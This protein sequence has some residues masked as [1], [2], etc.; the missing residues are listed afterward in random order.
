MLLKILKGTGPGVLFLIILTLI[1]VWISPFL[2][3]VS[4]VEIYYNERPMLLFGILRSTLEQNYTAGILFSMS[5]VLLISYILVYFNTSVF[6]IGERTYLPAFVYILLSGLI[7]VN[8]QLNPALPASL[9]LILAIMRIVESYRIQGTAFSFF[10]AGFLIATGSLFYANLIWYGAL[11]LIGILNIRAV[12]LKEILLSLTGLA[13]PFLLSI[14]VLYVTGNDIPMFLDDIRANLFSNLPAASPGRFSIIS[15][16]IVGFLI[17]ISAAYLFSVIGIK[18]IKSRKAF[19]IIIW[20][21]II[22]GVLYFVLPSA[23][24]ETAWI[25]AIPSAYFLSHFFTLYRRKTIQEILFTLMC[26]IVGLIQVLS[27]AGKA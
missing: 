15:L 14:G 3:P 24:I 17:L 23:S 13:T 16:A 11:L 7:P 22:S 27:I 5:L 26:F 18:K 6:F 4:P 2:H 25:I 12:N 19:S 1:L 21:L 8:Q 10:D 9:F 20:S